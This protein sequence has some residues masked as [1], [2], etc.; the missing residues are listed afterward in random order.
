M[1]TQISNTKLSRDKVTPTH[2][3][4]LAV[5]KS[6]LSCKKMLYLI[7]G[8]LRVLIIDHWYDSARSSQDEL[9]SGDMWVMSTMRPDSAR[10]PSS[11]SISVNKSQ[12]QVFVVSVSRRADTVSETRYPDWDSPNLSSLLDWETLRGKNKNDVWKLIISSLC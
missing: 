7:S 11:F 9:I 6:Q 4:V 5:S 3:S 12:N 1:F 2:Q 10:L 8:E